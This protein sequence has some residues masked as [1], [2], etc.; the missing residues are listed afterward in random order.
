MEFGYVVG[1]FVVFRV[2]RRFGMTINKG[3]A[4]NV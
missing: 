1:E 2:E 3:G 4:A